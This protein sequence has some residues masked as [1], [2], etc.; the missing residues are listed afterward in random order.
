L[1]GQANADAGVR[2]AGMKSVTVPVGPLELVPYQRQRLMSPALG[3]GGGG[4]TAVRA[5]DSSGTLASEPF[6]EIHAPIDDAALPHA[7]AYHGMTGVLRVP[8]HARPIAEPIWA[9]L[10]QLLQRH[11]SD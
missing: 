11:Y 9:S 6:F 10:Q 5:D 4:E 3:F 7:A 2:L 8:V 1:F